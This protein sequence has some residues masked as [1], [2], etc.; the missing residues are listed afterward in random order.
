MRQFLFLFTALTLMLVAGISF[1]DHEGRGGQQRGEVW[2]GG[3]PAPMDRGNFPSHHAINDR[4]EANGFKNYGQYLAAKH[5]SENLGIPLGA[6]RARVT[7][8][9]AVSLGRAIQELR[10]DLPP[11]R[12]YDETRRAEE[13]S[14]REGN[15]R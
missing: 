5:V 6:L 2:D 13:W 7:G 8:A 1:A 11:A 4:H 12:V 3:H 10:P 14:K 9:H 15:G